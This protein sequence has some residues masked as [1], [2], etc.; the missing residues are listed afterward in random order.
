MEAS[1]FTRMLTKLP[2][3]AANG[4]SFG[5]EITLLYFFPSV[6]QALTFRP[7]KGKFIYMMMVYSYTVCVIGSVI[8]ICIHVY[9]A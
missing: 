1:F 8:C 9:V 5:G 2:G 3:T 7:S 6:Q 4:L